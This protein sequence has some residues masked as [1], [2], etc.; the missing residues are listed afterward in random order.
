MPRPGPFMVSAATIFSVLSL[1][2]PSSTLSL[3]TVDFE[4]LVAL[5]FIYFSLFLSQS[6]HNPTAI[7]SQ[8]PLISPPAPISLLPVV[9]TAAR[10][11]IKHKSDQ[12]SHNLTTT[13]ISG[14]T[15][16]LLGWSPDNFTLW[17]LHL[18]PQCH[19]TT[20]PSLSAP[21]TLAVSQFHGCLHLPL[22]LGPS[23]TWTLPGTFSQPITSPG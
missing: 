5:K 3:S 18:S 11:T 21:P 13:T 10:V 22:D 8:L 14:G 15:P 6:S 4:L 17:G 19:P 20:L 7:A 12:V 2:L 9:H 16:L 1:P 23:L